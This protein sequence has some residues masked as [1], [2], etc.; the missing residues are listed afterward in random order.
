MR[1][2]EIV[3]ELRKRNP[4]NGTVFKNDELNRHLCCMDIS[5]GLC[6]AE[7]ERIMKNE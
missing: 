6:V 3:A 4:Y 1:N 2:E 7:L 5:W